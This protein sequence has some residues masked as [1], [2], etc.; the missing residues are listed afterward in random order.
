MSE[1]PNG[2][3]ARTGGS[4]GIFS[5]EGPF[6]TK[7][8]I[9]NKFVKSK[10]GKTFKTIDPATEKVIAKVQSANAEDVDIAVAAARAAF[11]EDS[12]WR[13]MDATKRRDL[14]WALAQAIEENMEYLSKLESLD[15]GKP[16]KN[17][18]YSSQVDLD[19][20]V[21]IYKYYAGW[22]DKLVGKVI[23]QE[24]A[25]FSF[26]RHEPVGVC[27]QIIPWNFPLLMMAWKLGPALACGCTVVMKTSEKT[28]LSALAVCKLIR[29]VGFPEGVVNVLSG[30]GPAAGEPLAMHMDVD[31]VAFTGSTAVGHKI[32]E[33][34]AKSNLKRVTLELGGKSPLIVM[35]DADIEQ[36]LD[37]AHIGL[38]LNMGQCCCASSRLFV[39]EDIYDS[40]VAGA[41]KRAKG[42]K[43]GSQFEE[44]SLHGP[45]VDKIQFDKVMDYISSGKEE[46][47]TCKIGGKRATET[48]YFVEPTVFADVTD[49][50]K[51]A[52]EEI[53]G[54]VMSIMK[55]KDVKD[56]I[57]RANDSK[58]G[59]AAGVMTRDIGN[60]L[61][62]SNSL[63]K[64]TV[65][66]NCYDL[67]DA[68]T[69]FGGF[70]ESGVGREKSE[71]A[72]MNYLEVKCVT[73]P[74]DPKF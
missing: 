40:F 15:N 63:R 65:W 52:K 72:L 24:G 73:M 21:K 10:S 47:A 25:I 35:P 4:L 7:L 38:F 33:C 2:K 44:T 27:G 29:E 66:V 48:G 53:F 54:P 61:K 42:W 36:A 68:A 64:G 23:P 12:E 28:P 26:T 3:R 5:P 60:A 18:A 14:L 45:Q 34:A 13:K 37:A 71:Y 49:D 31:K 41:V 9:N 58:Y 70:K 22:A 19:L 46:G 51:I 6:Q 32:M 43:H 74:I 11:E 50:M 17:A 30:F 1:E 20:V 8:F 67:F 16:W 59:L 69:P 62:I 57:K 39:H 55:F 56:A